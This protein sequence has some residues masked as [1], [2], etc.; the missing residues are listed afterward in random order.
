MKARKN[1]IQFEGS[2]KI[3]S[4]HPA[5]CPRI[6]LDSSVGERRILQPMR[7]PLIYMASN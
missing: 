3:S 1:S 7:P 6:S 4:R 2:L 5:N